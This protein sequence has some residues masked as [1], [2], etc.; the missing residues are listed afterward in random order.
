[1][2][3]PPLTPMSSM[4]QTK[5][6]EISF[7]LFSPTRRQHHHSTPIP[8]NSTSSPRFLLHYLINST[9]HSHSSPPTNRTPI[10]STS[11]PYPSLKT[12]RPLPYI[13]IPTPID[14]HFTHQLSL[15]SSTNSRSPSPYFSLK[16]TRPLLANP[17]TITRPK[18]SSPLHYHSTASHHHL[19]HRF[20]TRPYRLVPPSPDLHHHSVSSLLNT[21]HL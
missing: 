13:F 15:S 2:W 17:T 7:H 12:T 9:H 18:L 20:I 4:Q 21:Y 11:P 3:D 6:Q 10:H 16:T 5:G 8:L 19:L 1:M 14:S